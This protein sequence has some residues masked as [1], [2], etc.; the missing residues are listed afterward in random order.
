MASL[1]KIGYNCFPQSD[2]ISAEAIN[3][4]V[5][6]LISGAANYPLHVKKSKAI[7]PAR[8][9]SQKLVIV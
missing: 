3:V 7:A 1:L 8:A 2:T 6:F 5:F 9:I 4:S